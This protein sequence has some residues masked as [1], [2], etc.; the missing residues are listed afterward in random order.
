MS[1]KC[2]L[3]KQHSAT[4]LSSINVYVQEYKKILQYILYIRDSDYLNTLFM[5]FMIEIYVVTNSVL[6]IVYSRRYRSVCNDTLS[7]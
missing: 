7:S 2:S 6:L 3:N 1:I 5:L 4:L